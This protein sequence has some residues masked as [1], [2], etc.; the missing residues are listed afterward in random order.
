MKCYLIVCVNWEETGAES[1]VSVWLDKAKAEKEVK[2]L[3][4]DIV[5]MD[6]G[7]PEWSEEHNSRVSWELKEIEFHG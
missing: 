4:K 1:A 6:S 3:N 7:M 5:F 2:K